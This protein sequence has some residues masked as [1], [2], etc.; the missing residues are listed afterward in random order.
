MDQALIQ[1]VNLAQS[2]ESTLSMFGS[3]LAGV[4]VETHFDVALPAIQ[5]YGSELNQVWTALIENAID[6]MPQGGTIRLKTRLQGQMAMVEVWDS[7][8]GIAAELQSRIFE[9]FFT[10]KAP[11]SGLGLGLD[12]AHRIVT[13]HSG[14]IRVESKP[15]ATCFQVRLPVDQAEAY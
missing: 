3:R 8:Q 12:T 14:F 1:D 13:R 15:G 9:P 11:G 6:A 2:L 10:T 5:A 7:G 4:K